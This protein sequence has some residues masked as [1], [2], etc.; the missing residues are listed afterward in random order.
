MSRKIQTVCENC[1]ELFYVDR[2]AEYAKCPRCGCI[3]D[4]IFT[5][6]YPDQRREDDCQ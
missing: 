4:D 2:W 5:D 6:G 1:S 3:T